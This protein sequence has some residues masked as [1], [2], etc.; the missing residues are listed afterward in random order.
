MRN[1]TP[2]GQITHRATESDK[3]T[4]YKVP[5]SD[6]SLNWN[7]LEITGL[8]QHQLSPKSNLIIGEIRSKI[9]RWVGHAVRRVDMWNSCKILVG[10]LEGMRPLQELNVSEIKI[11]FIF[12]IC[13]II[14]TIT[15]SESM[16]LLLRGS[17]ELLSILWRICWLH[18]LT[19]IYGPAKRLRALRNLYTMDRI[20]NEWK[21]IPQWSTNV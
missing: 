4:Y 10:K 21:A 14:H 9:T 15:F 1:I 16:W 17:G 11:K 19:G 3:L 5:N 6:A 2:E 20:I 12:T 13:N 18:T 7:V 8:F